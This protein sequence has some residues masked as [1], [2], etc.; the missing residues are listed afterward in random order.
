LTDSFFSKMKPSE[1]ISFLAFHI[2]VVM[3]NRIEN[4]NESPIC[5]MTTN[6]IKTQM[7][8]FSKWVKELN[9]QYNLDSESF[10]KKRI[11]YFR[12]LHLQLS[13]QK[14][15][16]N[17]QQQHQ[18]IISMHDMKL[19]PRPKTVTDMDGTLHTNLRKSNQ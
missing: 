6:I 11:S 10:K 9:Q 18:N 17:P 14:C 5:R 15:F 7:V 16:L 8:E 3:G 4:G 1:F 13:G 2:E 19:K 12:K